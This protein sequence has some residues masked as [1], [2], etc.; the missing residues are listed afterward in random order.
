MLPCEHAA[1]PNTSLL[2]MTAKVVFN[3]VG[4]ENEE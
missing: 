3:K 4:N 1:T 2:I